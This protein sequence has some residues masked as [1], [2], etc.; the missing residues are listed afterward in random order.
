MLSIPVAELDYGIPEATA[1]RHASQED[2][3]DARL[4]NDG[5]LNLL[6]FPE[7]ED[8][9]VTVTASDLESLQP[10][11]FLGNNIIDFYVK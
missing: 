4:G 2:F 9:A 5:Q 3:G 8:D 7:G 6:T 10:T 1:S 11:R